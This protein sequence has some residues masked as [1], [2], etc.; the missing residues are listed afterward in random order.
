[1]GCINV[2]HLFALVCL[3][4]LL[5]RFRLYVSFQYPLT[6]PKNFKVFLRFQG[7]LKENIGTK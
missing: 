7:V 1:M 3:L 4:L 5:N 6:S 2:Q